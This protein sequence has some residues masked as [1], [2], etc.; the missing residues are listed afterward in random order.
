VVV[1]YD[2]WVKDERTTYVFEGEKDML[3]ARELGLNAITL[4]GGASAIPS[5]LVLPAF[6]GRDV[7]ICYDNDE[8]GRSG[9]E[10]MFRALHSTAKSVRYIDI[11]DVV[12]NDISVLFFDKSF[13][14]IF[15][16]VLTQNCPCALPNP[17]SATC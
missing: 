5:D 15:I 7:V 12:E 10:G 2:M 17:L 8:A 1:P 3:I 9:M 4:T 6:K 16:S 13:L 11:S 14:M